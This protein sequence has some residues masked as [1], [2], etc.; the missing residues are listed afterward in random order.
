MAYFSNAP[1]A[2]ENM[3]IAVRKV[4]QLTKWKKCTHIDELYKYAH[5]EY[6][7]A[8]KESKCI[9][10]AYISRDTASYLKIVGPSYRYA[11]YRNKIIYIFIIGLSTNKNISSVM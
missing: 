3:L 6:Q 5:L 8:V 7:K 9:T 1:S 2:I 4:F 11:F 10:R